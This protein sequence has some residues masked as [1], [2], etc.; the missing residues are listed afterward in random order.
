MKGARIVQIFFLI[1]TLV[2]LIFF[3]FAN[4]ITVELPLVNRWLP[5]IPVAYVVALLFLIGW[6]IGSLT[7]R[8][9]MWGQGRERKRLAE[10]VSELEAEL[11]RAVPTPPLYTPAT[12]VPVIPDRDT[13]APYQGEDPT[14]A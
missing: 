4:Q 1:V 12:A 8:L 13:D 14:T 6:L 5:T 3:H 2:Y 11:A 9:G 10:R 7:S